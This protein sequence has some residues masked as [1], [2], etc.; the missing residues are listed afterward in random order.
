[1][2]TRITATLLTATALVA[3]LATAGCTTNVTAVTGPAPDTVTVVGSGT[4]SATPD[5]ATLSMSVNAHARSATDAMNSATKA[6]DR[7]T[8]AMKGVGLTDAEMQ[9][10]QISVYQQGGASGYQANQAL[11]VKTKQIAK[12]GKILAEATRAGA[13]DISGPSFSLADTDQVQTLA[14]SRAMHDAKA[15]A[16]AMAKAAGRPLGRVVSISDAQ[17][18]PNYA[19]QESIYSLSRSGAGVGALMKGA[20]A[21]TVSPGRVSM[22]AQLSVVYALQ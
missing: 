8:A 20:I 14:I 1:M 5:R 11:T 12:L 4:G 16:T 19:S 17:Q 2:R 22:S 9:T 21:P 7:L 15:R 18:T 10:Q 3:L 6:M 13:S